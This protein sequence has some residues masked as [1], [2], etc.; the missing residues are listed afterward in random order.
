[1]TA[2]EIFRGRLIMA[3]MSRGTDLPFRRLLNE[4]GAEVCVGEMAYSHKVARGDRAEMA[5]LRRHPEEKIFGVQLAGKKPEVMAEAAQ[6]AE[7]R[8]ADFIDVNLGCPIDDATKRGYGAALLQRPGRVGDIV[9]AMKEACNV[10][11]TVKL[12]LGWSSEKPTYLKIARAAEQAGVDAV[13]LHSRSRA[14][15]YRRPADWSHVTELVRELSVPV[16][17]NGDILGWRDA[18]R[19]LE[20]TGCAAVMVGRW[21]LTKPWIFQEFRERRDIE[22]DPDERLAVVRR[23]VELCRELFRDDEKGRV[24]TRRFL[25]FHQDFFRRY[26]RGAGL[27][28]VNSDDPR[29]W[30]EPA[31]NEL[32]EWLCRADVPA[33]DAL[34][35]WLVD[36]DEVPPPPA[37]EPGSPRAVK[38]KVLG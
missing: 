21:A 14:Q 17:G 24:R 32:E 25:T 12:R 26:R 34:C 30:G 2:E 37:V 35:R 18:E 38:L 6:I 20:E 10:P 36:G 8:G 27:D 1:M 9:R 31:S 28:A 29:D 22:L 3:P 13:T 23:Y 16:I 5:L 15:R 4:W 11:I 19:R 33:T 7:D